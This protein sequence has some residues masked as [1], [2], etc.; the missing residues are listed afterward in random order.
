M[1]GKQSGETGNCPGPRI[2][3][4]SRE[5]T[6]MR[7]ESEYT[8][9]ANDFLANHGIT[10]K[11][12]MTPDNKCPLFCDGKHMHGNRHQVTLTRKED[13][14]RFT[15]MFWNSKNDAR[16]SEPVQAYDVLAC[17]TKNDPGSFYDFCNEYGYDED[18]RKADKTYK[19]VVKEWTKVE[20]FF[21]P[22]E[23]EEL[24]EIN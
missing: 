12:T 6:T 21:T 2:T 20:A 19:A 13:K 22:E 17:A 10:F 7:E 18:S 11:A 8:K 1:I 15:L 3:R 14:S 16:T 9:Q 4:K 23:I 24:C 5:V